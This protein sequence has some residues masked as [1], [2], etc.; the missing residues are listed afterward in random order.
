MNKGKTYYTFQF[1]VDP[2]LVN[3]MVMNW[4]LANQFQLTNK[5]GESFYLSKDMWYGKRGFQYSIVGNVLHIYAWTIG[6]GNTYF[7]LDAGGVNNM[8][9][10]S[11][12]NLLSLLFSKMNEL[13][14]SVGVQTVNNNNMYT[15]G[16]HISQ[17]T[18][19]FQDKANQQ[20]E[21]MCTIGF[22]LSIIG[23]LISLVGVAYGVI[24]YVLDF[25]FAAQGLKTRKRSMAIATIC[26]SI[27]SI[28][29]II[30]QLI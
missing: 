6:I 23:F 27:L 15:Q 10:V 26:L 28:A 3:Q 17:F 30:L 18:Q 14:A 7:M 21:R 11:Y 22:V 25:Y 9:S 16:P 1:N 29:I 20:K 19:E 13:N 24:V 5:N 4:L 2:N 8:A 12:K